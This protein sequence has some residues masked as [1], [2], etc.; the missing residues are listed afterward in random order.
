[1]KHHPTQ[2]LDSSIVLQQAL[3]RLLDGEALAPFSE[4][5]AAASL[6]ADSALQTLPA[7]EIAIGLRYHRHVAMHLWGL[8][9]IP[10]NRW[11]ARGVPKM[12]RNAPC[13]CGSG[14]KF[15][16]CCAEFEHLDFPL[17]TDQLLVMALE[18][19]GPQWLTGEKLRQV[20][21]QA[22]GYAAMNWNDAGLEERT[23]ALIEPLFVDPA[24]LDARHEVA[25][26]ALL[27]ALLNL[28]QD[29]QRR[30]LLERMVGHTDKAL[31]TAA[32]ARL[33]SV[34]ADQGEVERAWALFHE[35][36]R[37]NPNDPQLWPLELTLLL[38]QGRQEE[39]R[40]RAPLLAARARQ[41]GLDDL[42]VSLV[43]MAQDG[44]G[45]VHDELN[46]TVDDPDDLA[47][48]DLVMATPKAPDLEAL[49]ALYRVDRLP[50]EE[51]G[52]AFTSV[53]IRPVKKLADLNARWRRRFMVGKPDMTWLD[54]DV[55]CLLGSLP[56]AQA[57]MQKNPAAWLSAEVLDDLLLAAHELCDADVPSPVLKAARRLADHALAV[58]RALAGDGQ[59][60]WVELHHRPLLRCLALAIELARVARDEAGVVALLRLGL[61][62]NPHDN[63]GWRTMLAPLM[64]EQGLHEQALALLAQYPNDM[65]PSEHL[66]A[67]ALLGLG[68]K[69]E[70]ESVLR[71]AHA[72]YPLYLNALLPEA[73]DPPP[74]EPGPG[75]PLGGATAAWYHRM[76]WRPLWVR[77]GALA[78]ARALKLPDPPPTKPAK[79]RKPAKAAKGA[80]TRPSAAG[81]ALGIHALARP[82]GDKE[83]EC[84]RKTCS[85]YPR[86][87]GLMLAVAWS[88]QIL[89]PN[90]WLHL[91]INLHDRMPNSRTE[92]TASKALADTLGATM[93]L[94][95]HVNQEVLD[96]LNDP[97]PPLEG[98]LQSVALS[99]EA[100]FA[101]A[102]GFVQGCEMAMTAWA[103]KG[104][105]VTGNTGAFGRLRALAARAVV[106]AAQSRLEQDDGRP[107]LQALDD[108]AP[109]PQVLL[110]QSLLE[111]W[112][113]VV[114]SRRA[115]NT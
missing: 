92:A 35:T 110:M 100:V 55:D 42:A 56:D 65:P 83:E 32:R 108:T 28:G 54:G 25:L 68:Q 88:P 50:L 76:A 94:C 95:N 115:G 2:D 78:W 22:L 106:R 20:P 90:A 16:Q 7:D 59:L 69:A 18:G 41:A 57:F 107:L 10:A 93:Q 99:D 39:A 97:T 11:R 71:A 67:I 49:Q 112:P 52:K 64:I 89:M 58:L 82:F 96:H 111:L 74:E 3:T 23:V 34:L 1:M 27:D 30:L 46:D 14:R 109:S 15:K 4:W 40:L 73:M 26:D 19:A 33:V 17:A 62:L 77:S 45:A 86:L 79:V 61:S 29:G 114:A 103:R 70:A 84:L 104:H 37:F 47:W 21:A 12:E 44:I 31:A 85:D 13:H 63:H 9:P 48:L 102:A 66:H 101:W 80:T 8:M 5:F 60:H 51:H 91:A 24:R 36:S 98:L 105:K 87:H 53:S 113:T 43:R 75:L 6:A 81:K 72:D 38:T